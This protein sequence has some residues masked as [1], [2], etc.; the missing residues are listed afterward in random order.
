MMFL[1]KCFSE[2]LKIRDALSKKEF[3][4]FEVVLEV[5]LFLVNKKLLRLK[6]E[7]INLTSK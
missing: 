6:S 7:K 5:A 1:V 3:D 2:V 4:T